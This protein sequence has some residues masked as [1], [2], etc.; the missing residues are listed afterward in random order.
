MKN[1]IVNL[2]CDTEEHLQSCINGINCLINN[3]WDF[4]GVEIFN[5][6]KLIKEIPFP[7]Y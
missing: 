7:D 1:R 5:K 3:G 2:F 6:G 4:F